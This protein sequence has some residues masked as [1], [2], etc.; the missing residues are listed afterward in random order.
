MKIW[1][2]WKKVTVKEIN[3]DFE[4]WE[5]NIPTNSLVKWIINL[6]VKSKLIDKP[7]WE[8][9]LDRNFVI[10]MDKW[11]IYPKLYTQLAVLMK[12]KQFPTSWN[13]YVKANYILSSFF[14]ACERCWESCFSIIDVAKPKKQ[15]IPIVPL[16]QTSIEEYVAEPQIVTMIPATDYVDTMEIK[17]MVFGKK[18][19]E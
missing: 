1:I 16:S 18:R 5:F 9:L 6:L 12:E 13:E 17:P 14:E 8:L 19:Y 3:F 10:E 7:Q 11:P 4:F 15:E 2:T